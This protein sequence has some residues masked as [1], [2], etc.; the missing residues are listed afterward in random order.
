MLALLLR[1][2]GSDNVTLCKLS[3]PQYS[4]SGSLT[5]TL[6]HIDTNETRTRGAEDR[7]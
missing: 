4:H 6:C 1:L 3:P 5:L 7:D 2:R